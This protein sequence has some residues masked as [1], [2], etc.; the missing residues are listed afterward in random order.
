[1]AN[2][3][4]YNPGNGRALDWLE[5]V[6]TSIYRGQ[7]G[8]LENPVMPAGF[9][10]TV[11]LKFIKV[12]SGVPTEMSQAEKDTILINEAAA[13]DAAR[14][15]Q[16][17]ANTTSSTPEDLQWRAL[18]IYLLQEIKVAVPAYT[19]PNKQNALSAIQVIIDNQS[20]D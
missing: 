9:P 15:N 20:A 3:L 2:F 6:E 12:V 18:L 5:S 8:Y 19:K 11:P 4:R 10:A 14:R 13:M 7:A 1:M 17:K 16:S